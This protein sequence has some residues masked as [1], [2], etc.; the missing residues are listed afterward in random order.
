MSKSGII[1]RK[2]LVDLT[3][4]PEEVKKSITFL[5][6]EHMDQVVELALQEN[7]MKEVPAFERENH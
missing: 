1:P 7:P 5:S 2:N 3:D 4:M 6:V